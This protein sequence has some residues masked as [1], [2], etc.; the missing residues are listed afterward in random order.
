LIPAYTENTVLII[1][2]FS[3]NIEN[4]TTVYIHPS[5]FSVHSGVVMSITIVRIVRF[6]LK[7]RKTSSAM[8]NDE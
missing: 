2:L 5:S 4:T 1:P 3:T 8:H 6:E 7:E